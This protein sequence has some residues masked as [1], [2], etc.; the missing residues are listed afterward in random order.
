MLDVFIEQSLPDTD[1][2]SLN[3]P[4]RDMSNATAQNHGKG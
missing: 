2:I 1:S 4:T 3:D